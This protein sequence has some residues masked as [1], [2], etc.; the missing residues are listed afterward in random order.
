L[1][2]YRDRVFAAGGVCYIDTANPEGLSVPQH[3]LAAATVATV[4]ELFLQVGDVAPADDADAYAASLRQLLDAR[5]RYPAL[6]AGGTRTP[7][8]PSDDSRLY[9]FLREAEG[10]A[11]S[12]LVVL[13]FQPNPATI[14]VDLGGR[15]FLLRDI[16][17]EGNLTKASGRLTTTI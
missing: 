17:T 1:R 2:G 16:L 10:D 13:N 3:L 11:A 12:I 5:R 4:G 14:E 8:P 9:A 6:A 7:L 15:A